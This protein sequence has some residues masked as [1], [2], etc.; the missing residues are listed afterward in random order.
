MNK[1]ETFLSAWADAE[2]SSDTTFLEANLT[3]DFVGVGPLGFQLPKRAWLAR[4]DA[5]DLQ[6]ETFDLDEAQVRTRGPV[7]IVTARQTAIGAFQGHPL[8][9][10][11]RDTLL[12]V[13]EREEWQ[14]A[15]IHMSFIAGT[16]G[17]PPLPGVPAATHEPADQGVIA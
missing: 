16:P 14:L 15:G 2:R 5:A 8:P 7:A 10:A 9:E 1:I 17:A 4:H 3:D 11:L 13:R 6:Y 12:L